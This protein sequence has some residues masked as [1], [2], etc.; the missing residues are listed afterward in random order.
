MKYIDAILIPSGPS[1]K[2]DIQR[3]E[4]AIK[5]FWYG[6]N[7][8]ILGAGPDIYKAI[9]HQNKKEEIPKELDHHLALY[10]FLASK[11]PQ[12]NLELITKSTTAV[13]NFLEF[14][15]DNMKGNFI[16][17]SDYWQLMKYMHIYNVLKKK[18]KISEDVNIGYHVVETEKY[19]NWMKRQ[20]SKLKTEFRLF[21]I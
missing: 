6:R 4:G 12:E 19:Y 20:L 5:E 2:I 16:I 7:Y 13:Q 21:R 17:C 8:V 1:D 15:K 18:G 9:E 3:A 10:N 14:F 11:I